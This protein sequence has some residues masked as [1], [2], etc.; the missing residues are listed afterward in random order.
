MVFPQSQ[1]V[2]AAP[3]SHLMELRTRRDMSQRAAVWMFSPALKL[4]CLQQFALYCPGFQSSMS[5]NVMW[6][7][8]KQVQQMPWPLHGQLAGSLPSQGMCGCWSPAPAWDSQ[9]LPQKPTHI[10][11]IN[12]MVNN[13]HKGKKTNSTVS[14]F[15]LFGFDI[16]GFKFSPVVFR[17]QRKDK[18]NLTQ[19]YRLAYLQTSDSAWTLQLIQKWIRTE[20]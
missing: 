19:N 11:G 17:S 12:S 10:Q 6:Q 8:E 16:S 5:R 2:P 18:I 9:T 1:A 13:R 3:I 7:A 20:S 4:V 15:S 14:C